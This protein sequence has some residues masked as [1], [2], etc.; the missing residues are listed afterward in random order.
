MV[1]GQLDAV[2]VDGVADAVPIYQVAGFTTPRVPPVGPR[3]VGPRIFMDG[4]D[5]I[6]YEKSV[7]EA[8]W[9]AL[10][11][12]LADFNAES[13]HCR[14]LQNHPADP[15]LGSWVTKQRQRKKQLDAGHPSPRIT[16]ERVA[17]LDALGFEWSPPRGRRTC[18]HASERE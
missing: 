9:E 3:M 2:A 16:A 1:E 7:N 6:P 18:E 8:N 12:R 10:R 15:E 13:G 5:P 11:A 14:V 4:E 17:K